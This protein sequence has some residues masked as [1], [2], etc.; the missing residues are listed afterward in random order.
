MKRRWKILL[1]I[2]ALSIAGGAFTFFVFPGPVYWV[3][4]YWGRMIDINFFDR[5]EDFFP[6]VVG[7]DF[8]ADGRNVIVAGYFPDVLLLDAATGTLTTRLKGHDRWLEGA[9]VSPDGKHY[10]SSDWGSRAIVWDAATGEIAQNIVL[11]VTTAGK[12]EGDAEIAEFEVIG[13]AFHP[14]KNQLACATFLAPDKTTIVDLDTGKGEKVF[15]ANPSGTMAVAYS[16]DGSLLAAGGDG[17]EMLN[18][19]E[20]ESYSKVAT[21]L[22]REKTVVAVQFTS[23]GKHLLTCGDDGAV[24]FFD[25]EKRRETGR[26]SSGQYWVISCAL[27]P[28]DR[29]FLTADPDGAVRYWSIESDQPERVIPLHE[30]WVTSVKPRRDGEAFVSGG[31]DGLVNVYDLRDDRIVLTVDTEKFLPEK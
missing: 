28:D 26:W 19:Y 23:D 20:T 21:L 12:E 18:L 29:H 27:M 16:P 3:D 4:I 7:V 8:T 24:R 15:A 30:D 31:K 25:V 6:Y 14:L 1:V 17:T 5:Q 9:I 11:D 22:G 13:L 2:L 10:A